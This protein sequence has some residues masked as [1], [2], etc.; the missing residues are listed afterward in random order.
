M[1]LAADPQ[2]RVGLPVFLEPFNLLKEV[3]RQ[4]APRRASIS[5]GSRYNSRSAR[6]GRMESTASACRLALPLRRMPRYG[7]PKYTNDTVKCEYGEAV[8]RPH[9]LTKSIHT[10]MG[11]FRYGLS[12]TQPHIARHRAMIQNQSSC[13]ASKKFSVKGNP[14][15]F[16]ITESMEQQGQNAVPL[17]S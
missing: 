12:K 16:P 5:N 14:A 11:A 10:K 15:L 9:R 4:R 1:H 6:A 17:A 8:G 7:A 2:K 13:M 3:I